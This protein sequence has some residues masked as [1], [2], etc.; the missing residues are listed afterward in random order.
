MGRAIATRF[1]SAGHELIVFNRSPDKAKDLA[2]AGAQ[3]ASS[4]AAACAGREIVVTMLSDDAALEEVTFGAN[5]IHGAL[6]ENSIHLVMGTHG[7]SVVRSAQD[8]HRQKGQHLVSAPVLGR[9]DAAA[10]GQLGVVLAG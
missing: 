4:A 1:L 9:P 5:G 2:A 7:T 6:L 8:R 10:A 3:V